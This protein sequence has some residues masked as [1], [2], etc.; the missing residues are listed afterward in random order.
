[1]DV[2]G[3]HL[4]D[5]AT[6]RACGVERDVGTMPGWHTTRATWRTRRVT[7]AA[8]GARIEDGANVILDALDRR[9]DLVQEIG[10]QIPVHDAFEVD[11]EFRH[12]A[13]EDGRL[14]PLVVPE[15]EE[16]VLLEG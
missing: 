8:R 16:V 12:I 1:M 15:R 4:R 5:A 2:V 11:H 9:R 10:A 3:V 7:I 14:L 13:D 6:T